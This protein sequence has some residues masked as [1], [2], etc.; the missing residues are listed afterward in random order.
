MHL[1]YRIECTQHPS[2]PNMSKIANFNVD[3]SS[4]NTKIVVAILTESIGKSQN[5]LRTRNQ[6]C[7]PLECR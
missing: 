1:I 3:D 7:K 5:S 4:G 2:E 6:I